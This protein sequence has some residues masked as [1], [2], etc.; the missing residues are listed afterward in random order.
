MSGAND[1]KVGWKQ[2]I[3]DEVIEYG[4]NF[5]Y[6]LLFFGIFTLYRRIT[7]AE[8]Q[9][10]YLHYGIALVEALVLAKIIMLG[11]VLGLGRRLTD[12]PLIWITLYKT[13]V[14]A[15]WTAVFSLFEHVLNGLVHGKGLAGGIDELLRNGD[16]VLGRAL[17]V[18]CAFVPFFAFKELGRVLGEKK[19]FDLYFR[20]GIKTGSEP[21]TKATGE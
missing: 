10:T 18:F 8:Y 5:I 20:R 16:E 7:L 12:Q 15:L 3:L 19:I 11:D 21:A 4:I 9:I 14:F 17:M 6:L 2:K 1:K 13:V